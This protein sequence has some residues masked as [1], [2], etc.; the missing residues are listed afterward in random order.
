MVDFGDVFS[1]ADENPLSSGGVWGA[2]WTG[3]TRPQV[4]SNKVRVATVNDYGYTLLSTAIGR[5]QIAV[6]SLATWNNSNVGQNIAILLLRSADSP[7]DTHYEMSIIKDPA[8]S[9]AFFTIYR[10]VAGAYTQLNSNTNL[11]VAAGDVFKFT[12]KGDFLE[13]YQNS[14]KLWAGRDG[15]PLNSGK[16]GFGA[17]VG[18]GGALADVEIRSFM[19][20]DLPETIRNAT[21]RFRLSNLCMEDDGRFDDL[22]VRNWFRRMLPA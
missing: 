13:F 18:T 20:G 2:A 21:S 14:L 15:S 12:V 11:T 16:I 8:P 1:Q 17:H 3:T 10:S 9:T 4:V 7:T 6:L 19:G 5:N 22:D